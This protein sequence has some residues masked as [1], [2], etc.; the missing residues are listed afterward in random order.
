M[1]SQRACAL[2][3]EFMVASQA[4]F[5]RIDQMPAQVTKPVP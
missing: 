2:A 4:L 1:L 3:N 5:N